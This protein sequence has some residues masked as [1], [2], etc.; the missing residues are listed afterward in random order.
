MRGLSLATILVMVAI[1]INA[2]GCSS[3][4]STAPGTVTHDDP[5]ASAPP[6]VESAAPLLPLKDCPVTDPLKERDSP[7]PSPMPSGPDA[8]VGTGP[9]WAD[10][11]R[12]Q[13]LTGAATYRVRW[14]AFVPGEPVVV[15]KRLD[16]P[17][18][19]T[20]RVSAAEAEGQSFWNGEVTVGAGG[21]WLVTAT[22]GDASVG[23]V[24]RS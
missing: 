7:P 4:G 10:L 17:G 16:A 24:M 11:S 22:I 14:K 23:F 2:G 12:V 8:W 1:G 15:V 19:G 21:C 6:E 20:S 5:P 18:Q 3:G 13:G 9:L